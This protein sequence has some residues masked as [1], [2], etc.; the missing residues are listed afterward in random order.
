[1]PCQAC[2]RIDQIKRAQNPSLI[3]ELTESYVV[4][5]DDQGFE[6]W[7]ILL[8][9]DHHEHLAE[10]PVN[11]QA[12]LWQDVMN[13]AGA[14]WRELKPIR[15]NYECLGN[16]LHHIHWH[17]IPR[18]AS[19]PEPAMPV[20][21][22]GADERRGSLSPHHREDLVQRMRGALELPRYN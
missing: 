10:L 4:L 13:V 11:R 9:K 7:C 3:A 17:V 19:D 6:G 15:I 22:R 21:V 16:L 12:R 18:Y 8:L 2:E 20:W 5:A 14:I 1:M